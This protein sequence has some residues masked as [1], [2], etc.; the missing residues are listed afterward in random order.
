M[1]TLVAAR[2]ADPAPYVTAAEIDAALK[3]NWRTAKILKTVNDGQYGVTIAVHRGFPFGGLTHERVTETY[4]I[5]SG[6]ANFE[7]GG[8]LTNPFPFNLR[9]LG[10][11]SAHGTGIQA[12]QSRRMVPGDVATVLPGVPHR[13][14]DI[15]GTLTFLVT[16]FGLEA[17]FK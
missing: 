3:E 14:T 12:G 9:G 15:E 1:L 13:F 7:T 2:A 16:R 11:A 10:G 8:T 17:W 4:Q 5:L 6:A